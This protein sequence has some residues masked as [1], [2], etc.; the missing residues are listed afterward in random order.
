MVKLLP[1]PIEKLSNLM[2][3]D[4]L[5]SKIQELPVRIVKLKKLRHLFAEKVSD[6]TLPDFRYRTGVCIHSG[7][8]KLRDLQTLQAL[9][10]RDEGCVRR[11]GE[12]RQMRSI[13]IWGVKGSY[14]KGLSESLRQMEFLSHLSINA[15][16]EEEILQLD[17][18]GLNWLPPNLQRLSLGGRL[19]QRTRCHSYLGG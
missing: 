14:F 11:L 2:T 17:L 7:L 18:D 15:S 8:E 19:A 1:N 6:P 9:Q 3:L 4:L 13:R 12:L 16:G 10:V 5:N